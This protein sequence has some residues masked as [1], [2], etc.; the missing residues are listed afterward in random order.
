MTKQE[1]ID[2]IT[3]SAIKVL[4]IFEEGTLGGVKQ[5][6]ANVLIGNRDR[7][8][9]KNI[10]FYVADEGDPEE[11]AYYRDKASNNQIEK[12]IRTYLNSLTPGTFLRTNLE[13]VNEDER[14]AVATV[15]EINDLDNTQVDKKEIFIYNVGQSIQHKILNI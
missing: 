8:V 13:R 12:R 9:V 4:G 7:T 5:Y 11:S 15:Y 3:A 2:E 14:F 6:R 10:G 1:I